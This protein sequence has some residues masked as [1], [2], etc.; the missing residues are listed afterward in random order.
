MN[1]QA[2]DI[3][4]SPIRC[5]LESIS[6][7]W[8]IKCPP[9][10]YSR[11]RSTPGHLLHLV[12]TGAY[13]LRTNEREYRICAGDVIYYHEV[14]EVRWLGNEEPVSF[15]SVA[16]QAPAVQ[17]LPMDCRVLASDRPVRDAF[18]ELFVASHIL[19]LPERAMR[20]HA[21]LL[22]VLWRIE[23]RIERASDMPAGGELWW[24]IERIIRRRRLFRPTL[25][26]LAEIC[27][28]S[29]ASVVRACQKATGNSPMRR[30]RQL[31][32]AEAHGLL[33]CSTLNIT[34]VAQYLGYPRLH[35]FSREFS[36][37]FHTPPSHV[38][39][40]VSGHL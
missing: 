16:F 33:T 2:L 23:K 31:R 28:T 14:E 29:R 13:H 40:T 15:Y 12:L 4:V 20:T 19:N 26:E 39:Q 36:R 25:D 34:Q 9:R 37:Y 27:H 6:G 10:H 18:D 38:R 11:A 24:Q 8:K 30:V 17:P 35:E 21:A 5:P 1:S 32:M 7:I 3:P 22:T